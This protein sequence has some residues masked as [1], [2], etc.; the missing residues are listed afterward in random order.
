MSDAKLAIAIFCGSGGEYVAEK[1]VGLRRVRGVQ[2]PLRKVMRWRRWKDKG[3]KRALMGGGIVQ[4]IA[5]V[6]SP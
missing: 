2:R 3:V 6:G 5:M 1:D 4:N